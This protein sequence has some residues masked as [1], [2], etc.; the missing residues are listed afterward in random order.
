MAARKEKKP[1]QNFAKSLNNK[2][3]GQINS[4]VEKNYNVAGVYG[5]SKFTR[6]LLDCKNNLK[7]I[8]FAFIGDSNNLFYPANDIKFTNNPF[9][10]YGTMNLNDYKYI[11]YGTSYGYINGLANALLNNNFNLYGTAIEQYSDTYT[12]DAANVYSTFGGSVGGWSS[13]TTSSSDDKQV[14]QASNYGPGHTGISASGWFIVPTIGKNIPTLNSGLHSQIS[15]ALKSNSSASPSAR[16]LSPTHLYKNYIKPRNST[17]GNIGYGFFNKAHSLFAKNYFD[18]NYFNS[19]NPEKGNVCLTKTSDE[20]TTIRGGLQAFYMA[21]EYEH[22]GR[23]NTTYLIGNGNPLLNKTEYIFRVLAWESS[24]SNGTFPM[25]AY[26]VE[27]ENFTYNPLSMVWPASDSNLS[28]YGVGGSA[29][30]GWLWRK[31]KG[32][33]FIDPTQASNRRIVFK[34]NNVTSNA[35][36]QGS[37]SYDR[38]FN[39]NLKTTAIRSPAFFRIKNKGTNR[40]GGASSYTLAPRGLISQNIDGFYSEGQGSVTQ[41]KQIILNAAIGT[42]FAAGSDIEISSS[43]FLQSKHITAGTFIQIQNLSATNITVSGGGNVTITAVNTANNTIQLDKQITIT[44]SNA[45]LT[46]PDKTP[47]PWITGKSYRT[48]VIG[49]II[50][51]EKYIIL[52]ESGNAITSE[53]IFDN[54]EIEIESTS[55]AG[56]HN[57]PTISTQKTERNNLIPNSKEFSG[58]N[59]SEN[60]PG[61]S[62]ITSNTPVSITNSDGVEFAGL[63]SY[64]LQATS[65]YVP[66]KV[67]T[68]DRTEFD[69]NQYHYDT[70]SNSTFSIWVKFTDINSSLVLSL[71]RDDNNLAYT[72]KNLTPL[73]YGSIPT[74]SV[75]TISSHASKLNINGRWPNGWDNTGNAPESYSVWGGQSEDS[76]CLFVESESGTLLSSSNFT[77]TQVRPDLSTQS[78]GYATWKITPSSSALNK[79]VR[80]SINRSSWFTNVRIG[81]INATN[82]NTM[83]IALPQLETFATASTNILTT[84]TAKKSSGEWKPREA[85]YTDTMFNSRSRAQSKHSLQFEFSQWGTPSSKGPYSIGAIS[86]YTKGYGFAINSLY[87]A[88]GAK[89]FQANNNNN[90]YSSILEITPSGSNSNNTTLRTLLK[91]Y[92]G[93]QMSATNNTSG[94]V[95]VVVQGGANDAYGE[96]S[97]TDVIDNIKKLTDLLYS[98]W[99]AC[100]FLE[101]DFHVVVVISH[102]DNIKTTAIN[103]YKTAIKTLLQNDINYANKITFIDTEYYLPLTSIISNNYFDYTSSAHCTDNDS[104]L[105]IPST[106]LVRNKWYKITT[107]GTVNWTIVGA[108]ST[109]VGTIFAATAESTTTGLGGVAQ[110]LDGV[111]A[112]PLYSAATG[113]VHLHP[114]GYNAFWGGVLT[115]IMAV[116]T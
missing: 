99:I 56:L 53:Q 69:T 36:A 47:C 113:C 110:L 20:G 30:A 88:S 5:S 42:S 105:G 78:S 103:S 107:S 35:D 115:N 93:R 100:G 17:N 27:N 45:T 50:A 112:T 86:V 8:D 114:T 92:R 46:I 97:S 91:E 81:Y 41:S 48:D 87:S 32:S 43:S 44:G 9:P 72:D 3:K 22:V 37:P 7:S 68:V 4:V 29:N 10:L 33:L 51:D 95:C 57:F 83:S 54:V 73:V 16:D 116:N 31:V 21:P 23:M 111:L 28:K 85:V 24:E 61:E 52:N 76:K 89:I 14:M 26:V 98:E 101:R 25:S 79:W 71:R 1:I 84:G 38:T 74:L 90:M 94:R 62:S 67:F 2:Y 70:V 104:T 18:S 102:D 13:S 63:T 80:F 60:T 82:S 6:W 106:S 108:G 12:K 15:Y 66:D 11:G 77:I 96:N 40:S 64:N 55:T 59:W 39:D 75:D 109:A 49:S 65:G 19:F 34:I 58:S